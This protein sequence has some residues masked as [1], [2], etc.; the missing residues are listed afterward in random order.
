VPLYQCP[1]CGEV[2]E[3]TETT[4]TRPLCPNHEDRVWML[5]VYRVPCPGSRRKAFGSRRCLDCGQEIDTV[6]DRFTNHDW[7]TERP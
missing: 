3:T 1:S 2:V 6:D 4:S 5:R 7:L